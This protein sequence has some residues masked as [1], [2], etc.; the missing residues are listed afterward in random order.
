MGTSIMLI[1]WRLRTHLNVVDL[2][3]LIIAQREREREK[4]KE[5]ER[6]RERERAERRSPGENDGQAPLSASIARLER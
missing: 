1:A 3:S 4:E 6:K 5:K 2:N